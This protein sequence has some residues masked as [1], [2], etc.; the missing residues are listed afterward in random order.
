VQVNVK[1]T[2]KQAEALDLMRG[3]WA[4]PVF[5]RRLLVER[6]GSVIDHQKR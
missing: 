1:L 4:R 3:G 6:I 5:L 2:P